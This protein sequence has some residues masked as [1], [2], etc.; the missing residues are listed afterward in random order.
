MTS[1]LLII[2]VFVISLTMLV[3]GISVLGNAHGQTPIGTPSI[4]SVNPSSFSSHATSVPPTSYRHYFPP[5]FNAKTERSNGVVTPLYSISPAPMGV[6]SWGVKNNSGVMTGYI[7]NTS[8]FEGTA[9]LNNLTTIDL[10]NDGPDQYTM[11]L[12]TIMRN[13]TVFGNT[14]FVFWTQNVV[15]Y[16]AHNHTLQFEDN[17][18]N[19]SSPTFAFNA[20]SLYNYDGHVVG[21]TYYYAVGPA[22][23]VT[24]P[25]TIHLFLNSTTIDNRNAVFFNYSLITSNGTYSGSYDR[26]IFNSTFGMPS[27]FVTPS[28][29]FQINGFNLTPT[30]FLPYDAELM[31]GG[32]GGGSTT[33]VFSINGTMTLSYLASSSSGSRY[34]SVP[35]AYDF[36]TDTGETASGIAEW[37][38]GNTVHLGTGPSILYPMWNVSQSSG[39]QELKGSI[40]PSNSFVFI[41]NG[42]FN[43]SYAAWAPLSIN[44]SFDYKLPPGTYSGEILMSEYAQQ[45]FSFS[46]S[47]SLTVSLKKDVSAGIYTPLIAMDNA[48]LQYISSGGSG[49]STNPY[50]IENNQYSPI[51]PLFWEWNDYLFPVFPGIMLVNTDAYVQISH[52]APF[53]IYYPSFTFAELAFYGLPTFNF[54][55]TELYGTSHV[56]IMNSEF[57]GWFFSGQTG[58]P[59]GNIIAW[60]ATSTLI[61]K[62]NFLSM[63]ESVVIYGGSGNLIW[64]NYFE[65]SMAVAPPA[66][67][68]YG[69]DPIGLAVYSSGNTI[70]NN[71][72]N[73]LITAYSPA[74]NIYNG[75]TELYSNTWNVT[76]EPSSSVTMFNG[77]SL[78]GSAINQ[79]YVSG[80]T[81][82]DAFPG[83]AYNDSGL[84]A[85]GY[86]YS[87]VFPTYFNVTVTLSNLSPGISAEVYLVQDSP[88]QYLFENTGAS[89]VT[90]PV[91]NGTYFVV[92]V[93]Q[94]NFYFNYQDTV[95]VNGAPASITVNL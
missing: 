76:S 12:N 83:Q 73:V 16:T 45:N 78:S 24:Y 17:I 51:S 11:Q 14:N 36:G 10:T 31:I 23:S 93:A 19:F 3:P 9:T 56:S 28:A 68:A 58:F 26:V 54:L 59:V 55:P 72:F 63:G 39:Y 66:S 40:T 90:V 50:I 94:G 22:I 79:G 20:T 4:A 2:I 34:L 30:N 62:N 8:S 35:S 48:Q 18:W 77:Y 42:T 60:N 6:G 86:D 25:F 91:Y 46:S 49:T 61:S 13:V 52:A 47:G 81:Y 38:S 1:K 65:E 37:W 29:Y 92:V 87:P 75:A 74:Y 82:W 84:I 85:S 67:L 53:L 57:T 41:S 89:T 43:D 33:N 7:L 21:T 80:N 32:P 88:Y 70:F 15:L 95:T 27:S 69:M 44:G 5:N 64:G 71:N